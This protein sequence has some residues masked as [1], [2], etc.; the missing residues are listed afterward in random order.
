MLFK[1][2]QSYIVISV[3]TCIH[4][5]YFCVILENHSSYTPI[6]SNCMMVNRFTV[7][8]EFSHESILFQSP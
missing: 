5:Q 1:S 2:K 6:I 8:G 7:A 3:L 4:K